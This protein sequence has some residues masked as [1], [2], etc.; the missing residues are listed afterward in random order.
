MK[1]LKSRFKHFPSNKPHFYYILVKFVFWMQDQSLEDP[2]TNETEKA[3]ACVWNEKQN[4]YVFIY[5]NI[6][7]SIS[8]QI[9]LKK[10]FISPLLCSN[11]R[12]DI[13]VWSCGNYYENFKNIFYTCRLLIVNIKILYWHK[14]NFDVKFSLVS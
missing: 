1:R 11:V 12:G 14:S 6:T 5:F 7:V 2:T 3:H 13:I 4:G 10:I 9:L 8:I